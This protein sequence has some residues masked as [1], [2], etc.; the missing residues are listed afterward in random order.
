[1]TASGT[2]FPTIAELVD[3]GVLRTIETRYWQPI[4]EAARLEA[5]VA[6]DEFLAAAGYHP[7]MYSDHGVVHVRDVAERAA[8]LA[9]H[10]NGL[11]IEHRL[12]ERLRVVTGAAVL[13]TY[14][15][16]IGMSADNPLGRRAH[17]QYAAHVAFSRGFTDVIE[18]LLAGGAVALTD[19]V[20]DVSARCHTTPDLVLREL[21]AL[22]VGHSKSSV[23]AA[24]LNDRAVLRRLV[25][26]ATLRPLSTTLESQYVDTEP[27][28]DGSVR[29]SA[30]DRYDEAGVHAPTASFV[31]L[32]MNQERV[33]EFANDVV[34]ALRIVRAADALRQRGTTLRTSA[35]FE[36]CCDRDT[37]FAFF[38]MRAID[39]RAGVVVFDDNP[40]SGA[41]A[42][43]RD[44]YLTDAA[45]LHISLH[46]GGFTP[47][48]IAR[49]AA[50]NV[51]AIV[52]DIAADVLDSFTPALAVEAT[53]RIELARPADAPGFAD[54]VATAM[55]SLE[56]RLADRIDVIDM[57]QPARRPDL[58]DWVAA[59]VPLDPRDPLVDDLFRRLE[60][61]GI[62]TEL[63]DRDRALASARW[64]RLDAG[65]VVF[66]PHTEATAV[67]LPLG[68]GLEIVPAGGYAPSAVRPF[69]PI[70]LT[71]VLRNGERNALVT[72][73]A[74]VDVLAISADAY[75]R[76]WFR[77]YRAEELRT[78]QT[79]WQS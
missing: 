29:T 65:T 75:L 15:H 11:L 4:T 35:G 19:E 66:E 23:P 25:Q 46:R 26:T 36:I 33:R 30:H 61:H 55:A 77:P 21:F 3:P 57:P 17:A 18:S 28:L 37:G 20:V 2:A 40:I 49:R 5:L 14:L 44:S 47:D 56:P 74:P 1:M 59:G 67:L 54:W 41:E 60:E 12:P 73:T 8:T 69:M 58:H 22:S 31:W 39:D 62:R 34:D 79:R 50:S 16:D 7:G 45:A 24:A 51:A 63:I 42:N 48:H 68:D 6:D 72:A 10:V 53:L 78:M 13:I 27:P 70:G 32:T 38:A 43:I 9:G 52:V 64:V 76:H 71:G